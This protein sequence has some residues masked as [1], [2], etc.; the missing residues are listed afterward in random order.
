M[1][2]DYSVTYVPGLYPRLPN[3]RCCCKGRTVRCVT[4]QQNAALAG[5]T[6]FLAMS[7]YRSAIMPIF[8]TATA[9]I[10]CDYPFE[11]AAAEER[12]M[13]LLTRHAR[14]RNS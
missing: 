13:A 9:I 6:H 14:P 8:A 5:H 1:Y 11:P 3:E 7:V 10:K 12:S 4:A 2:P